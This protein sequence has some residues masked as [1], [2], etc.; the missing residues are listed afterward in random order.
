[1]DA[2][3]V[4]SMGTVY[5]AVSKTDNQWY[6]VKVLPRRSM[7]NVR[8]A[9]RKVRAFE[10]CRHPA[11][12]PFVDVGTAGSMHYLAWPF[13]EGEGLDKIVTARG[14][15]KSGLAAFYALQVAEALEVCHQQA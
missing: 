1:M 14:K 10:A 8:V 13:V 7:W 15:L 12:V 11:V 6:A 2:L 4:G 5:K 3:G 9:R